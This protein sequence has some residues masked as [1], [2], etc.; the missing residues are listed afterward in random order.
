MNKFTKKLVMSALFAALV[1]VATFIIRI[2]SPLGGYMNLGDAVV[3]L[4]G[5]MLSPLY[6]VAAAGLGSAIADLSSGYV[7]YAPITFLIKGLMAFIACLILKVAKKKP[8]LGKIASAVIAELVM[9]GGYYIFE[10]FYYHDFIAVLANVPA[11]AIQGG[12]GII[13]AMLLSTVFDK[14]KIKLD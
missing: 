13:I 9:I 1:C 3:L 5:W 4:S 10:G 7:A 11:N 14:A 2:P 8:T 12:C 6:A